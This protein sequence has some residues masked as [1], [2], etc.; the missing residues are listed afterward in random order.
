MPNVRATRIEIC[1]K[2]LSSSG[3]IKGPKVIGGHFWRK[4]LQ[5]N[6]RCTLIDCILVGSISFLSFS[7]LLVHFSSPSLPYFKLSKRLT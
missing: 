6:E 5:E 2:T 3:Q 4:H 1:P 7:S